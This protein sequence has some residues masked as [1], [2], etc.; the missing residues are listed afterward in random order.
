MCH[1]I[2][3]CF[4]VLFSFDLFCVFFLSSCWLSSENGLI[5]IFIV[6]VLLIGLLNLVILV[7]VIRE[8]T[9]MH[10]TKDNQSEK[11]RLGIK[12]CL[13]MIPLLG[14]TWLFGVL[15][16]LHKAFAYI[17]T[18]FNSTQGFMIFFLHCVRNTEIRSRFKRKLHSIFPSADNGTNIKRSSEGNETAS[19]NISIKKTIAKHS[20]VTER[21]ND[22][23]EKT[24]C[25]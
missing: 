13:V 17:F 22:G 16:S 19:G 1:L 18:I 21:R 10:Q 3:F 23:S 20:V 25:L 9:T 6:F 24:S 2:F 11:I 7:R 14:V 5:W 12:A 8:M 15:S 4:W